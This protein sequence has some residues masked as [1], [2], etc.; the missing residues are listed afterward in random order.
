MGKTL[1]ALRALGLPGSCS[2]SFPPGTSEQFWVQPEEG[3]VTYTNTPFAPC[4]FTGLWS[5]QQSLVTF[6]TELCNGEV[7]QATHL[8]KTSAVVI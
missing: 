4:N 6:G 1:P 7:L 2:H 8:Q 3:S 5:I